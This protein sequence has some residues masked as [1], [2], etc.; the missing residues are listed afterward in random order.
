VTATEA[1]STMGAN[2]EGIQ[3]YGVSSSIVIT[4]TESVSSGDG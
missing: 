3:V 1:I 2:A 4:A